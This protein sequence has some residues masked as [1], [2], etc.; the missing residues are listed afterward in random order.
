MHIKYGNIIVERKGSKKMLQRCLYE[1]KS[2]LEKLKKR[3]DQK[4]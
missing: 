1:K 4:R 2:R 3:I